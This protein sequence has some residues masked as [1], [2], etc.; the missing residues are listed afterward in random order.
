MVLQS[1]NVYSYTITCINIDCN[2]YFSCISTYL[3]YFF[4]IIVWLFLWSFA[5]N[6]NEAFFSEFVCSFCLFPNTKVWG[7]IQL[8]AVEMILMSQREL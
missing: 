2:C 3:P 5:C 6:Q 7:I 4:I 8:V 1:L